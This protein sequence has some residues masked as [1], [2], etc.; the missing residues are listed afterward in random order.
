[1]NKM[2]GFDTMDTPNEQNALEK[3]KERLDNA[4]GIVNLI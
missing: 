2:G 1:M 4:L 3:R